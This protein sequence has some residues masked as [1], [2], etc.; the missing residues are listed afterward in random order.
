MLMAP[1]SLSV[2]IPTRN[3]ADTLPNLLSDLR[4]Q[5]LQPAEIIVA[6]ARSTDATTRIASQH[7]A[8]VTEGGTPAEGRNRGAEIATGDLILFLDADVRIGDD[9]IEAAVEKLSKEDIGVASFGF[10]V[11]GDW[12]LKGAHKISEIFFHVMSALGSPHGIGGAILVRGA[13]HHAIGGFDTEVRVS[14]DNEYLKRAAAE[15]GYRFFGSPRV[16]L[17]ARRFA[18]RGAI[19]MGVMWIR[20]ELHRLFVG[21]IRSDKFNYFDERSR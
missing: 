12:R 17:S 6:D 11:E 16:M 7:G 4:R 21:E 18:R 20:I 8:E 9:F 14:E 10:S 19:A 3:E 5:H 2:V 1:V 15:G 13:V